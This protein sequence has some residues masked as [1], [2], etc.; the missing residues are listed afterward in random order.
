V[1]KNNTNC[2]D[3]NHYKIYYFFKISKIHSIQEHP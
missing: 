3:I 2:I 1:I